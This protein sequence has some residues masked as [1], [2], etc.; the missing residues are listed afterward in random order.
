MLSIS[1]C[2]QRWSHPTAWL[3]GPQVAH[4]CV[5]QLTM[6]CCPVMSPQTL[7]WGVIDGVIACR[8]IGLW[9]AWR[10]TNPL[11]CVSHSHC[12]CILPGWH[13]CSVASWFRVTIRLLVQVQLHVSLLPAVLRLLSEATNVRHATSQHMLVSF[14]RHQQARRFMALQGSKWATGTK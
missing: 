12:M 1:P 10:D 14:C 8:P 7:T 3:H 6:C 13:T 9:R 2:D 11:R 5:F 4:R